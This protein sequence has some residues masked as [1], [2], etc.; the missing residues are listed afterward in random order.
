MLQQS[1]TLHVTTINDITM[2]PG[3]VAQ[4]TSYLPQEQEDPG[5]N[6]AR[7]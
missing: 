7:V 4:W 6:P 1:V 3:G 2:C 5:L